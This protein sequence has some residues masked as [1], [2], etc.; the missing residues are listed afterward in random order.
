MAELGVRVREALAEHQDYLYSLLVSGG[1]V[2]A[3]LE[4]SMAALE[5]REV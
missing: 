3:A 5:Q 1:V 4:A 2:A